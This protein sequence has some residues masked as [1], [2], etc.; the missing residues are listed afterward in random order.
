MSD[1]ARKPPKFPWDYDIPNEA[2]WN[3]LPYT[4]ARN[5]LSCYTPS[6][7]SNMHFDS[8]LSLLEK[9]KFLRQYLNTTFTAK[10]E[11]V[12]PT[13]LYEADYPAWMNLKLAMCSM[14]N[15]LG[16]YDEQEKL[17]REMYER[18]PDRNKRMSAL[19]QLAG[20]LMETKRYAEAESSEYTLPHHPH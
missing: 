9:L 4:T 16:N 2:F 10:E 14:E 15:E 6:Q 11:E 5:F 20:I 8:T 18:A 13:P 7:I 12:A 1:D 19:H 3:S 17:V